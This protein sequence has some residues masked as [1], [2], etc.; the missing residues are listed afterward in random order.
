MKNIK[1]Y[2][3]IVMAA[4]RQNG[5]A[6]MFVSEDLRGDRDIVMTAVRQDGGVLM[7]AS[8]DLQGDR[9]IVMTALRQNGG[10]LPFAYGIEFASD[11]LRRTNA[12]IRRRRREVSYPINLSHFTMVNLWRQ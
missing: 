4:V 5:W 8:D 6:L 1:G 2:G 10:V 9:D 7:F 11:N 3:E 12:F